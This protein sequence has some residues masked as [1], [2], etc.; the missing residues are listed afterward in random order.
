MKA[1]GKTLFRL[2]CPQNKIKFFIGVEFSSEQELI[3][4]FSQEKEASPMKDGEIFSWIWNTFDHLP[5]VLHG[6]KPLKMSKSELRR[7][8]D[9]GAVIFNSRKIS[10]QEDFK[11]DD[12]PIRDFAWFP[13]GKRRTWV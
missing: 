10:S 12:F 8:M 9:G 6:D 4:K 2:R 13:N 1:D 7:T 3:E 11:L 5:M